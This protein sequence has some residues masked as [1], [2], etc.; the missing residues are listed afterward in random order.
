MSENMT[1]IMGIFLLFSSPLVACSVPDP[2]PN[3][4]VMDPE[5]WWL[6]MYFNPNMTVSIDKG[7]RVNFVFFVNPSC[8][9]N[10]FI[11]FYSS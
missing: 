6:G 10:I 2:D 5:H 3:Q 1:N 9:P 7:L 8:W 4:N 11:F